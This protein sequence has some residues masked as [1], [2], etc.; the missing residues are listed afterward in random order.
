MPD[1]GW[2]P[3]ANDAARDHRLSWRARGL[4]AELLSYPDG[5]DVNVDSLVAKARREGGKAEGRDAMLKAVKE[6]KDAGYVTYQRRQADGGK[7][8]TEMVVTD[9]PHS[10][11]DSDR[12]PESKG[13]GD[14]AEQE[15]TD[16]LNPSVSVPPADSN[17][18]PAHADALEN[19][20]PESQC[21]TKKTVTKTDLERRKDQRQLT[22]FATRQAE[23]PSN[24][25]PD[26]YWAE[27]DRQLLGLPA[28]ASKT[29][30]APKGSRP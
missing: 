18:S 28:G 5:W 11:D 30:S 26:G 13:V 27:L 10:P 1:S 21:V 6:L 12:H 24:D 25:D 29:K 2:V 22:S 17:V 8:T 15:V 23:K 9:V 19:R 3:I 20:H 4:L 7:W 16:T 14:P